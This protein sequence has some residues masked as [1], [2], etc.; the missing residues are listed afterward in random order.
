MSKL[1]ELRESAQRI[2]DGLGGGK[3]IPLRRSNHCT[4]DPVVRYKEMKQPVA[5][6]KGNTP[7]PDS[8]WHLPSV[9]QARVG[10][11]LYEVSV[12]DC[13]DPHELWREHEDMLRETC[14]YAVKTPN[15]YHFYTE[16]SLRGHAVPPWVDCFRHPHSNF[17]IAE[18][19]VMGGFGKYE[20]FW[21]SPSDIIR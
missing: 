19:S 17:V 16:E 20:R 12:L 21:G 14:P 11:Q 18:G 4:T 15:G 1:D 7:I 13:V 8:A 3:L 10:L 2:A 9:S 5:K 6:W